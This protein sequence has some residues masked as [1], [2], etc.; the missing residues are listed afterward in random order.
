MDAEVD[1]DLDEALTLTKVSRPVGDTFLLFDRTRYPASQNPVA[2]VV[3][4]VRKESINEEVVRVAFKGGGLNVSWVDNAGP[5]Q[6]PLRI[7]PAGLAPAGAFVVASRQFGLT[8]TDAFL[9][10][11]KGD[12]P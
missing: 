10:R 8:Q 9:F 4:D 1:L 5:G 6:G 2:T 12:R 11:S 3:E 7:G